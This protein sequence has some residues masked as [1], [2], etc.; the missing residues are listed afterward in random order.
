MAIEF[1]ELRINEYYGST[2]KH[3]YYVV[4][5]DGSTAMDG[6]SLLELGMRKSVKTL[7]S[8][9]ATHD[10]KFHSKNIRHSLRGYKNLAELKIA[11]NRFFYFTVIDKHI[12]FFD[13]CIKKENRLSSEILASIDKKREKYE[14]AFRKKI[15]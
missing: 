14:K 3:V 15:F 11:F 7:I 5:N 10:G 2:R 1:V 8:K 6:F 9:L 13:F 4:D 12:I